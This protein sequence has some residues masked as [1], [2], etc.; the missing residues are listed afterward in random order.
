[1]MIIK[2]EDL[3]KSYPVR[4]GERK[5]RIEVLK[6][7][8]FEVEEKEFVGIMGRSGCGK[9]TLLKALGM[10]EYATD[11]KL[12]FKDKDTDYMKASEMEDLRR[13]GIGY[14]FQDYYLLDSLTVRENIVLP[15]VLDNADVDLMEQRADE[16][17]EHYNM[18]HLL[19]KKPC[20]LSGGEKQRVAICRALIHNPDL[21]LADEPTGNLDSKS[22]MIVMNALM[23]INENEGKTIIMVTHDPKLASYCNRILFLKDGVILDEIR[24]TGKREEFYRWILDRMD[25]L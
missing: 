22:G 6:G 3:K 4:G 19:D 12:W 15:L 18:M 9:T 16:Y 1:M 2:A 20:D 14:I 7:I 21:I 23:D 11:G 13:N 25:K 24:K 8:S 17:A 10:I 5:D